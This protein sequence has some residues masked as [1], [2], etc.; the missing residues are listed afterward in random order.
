MA[1]SAC[2]GKAA[3]SEQEV[4][5]GWGERRS[6]DSVRQPLQQPRLPGS[7]GHEKRS[8]LGCS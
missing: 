3:V 6:G 4:T 2:D 7:G 1:F 5:G 8:Q